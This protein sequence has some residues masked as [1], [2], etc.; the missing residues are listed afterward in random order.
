[1]Y[2]RNAKARRNEAPYEDAE[3]PVPDKRT[4]GG[5]GGW[6]MRSEREMY[7]L[8]ISTAENDDRIRA[9][10]MNG[11]RTNPNVPKD[12]FQDYDIVYVVKEN[13]PFYEDKS[14][15]DIF[16]ERLYMQCPDEVDR[17]NGMSVD[18][19]KC[20]GWLIQFQDGNRLDLHV[21]PVEEVNISEDKLCK[22]LL[23]KDGILGQ[24]PEPSDEAYRIR[25][26]SQEEFWACC[27]EFWWCLNNIAKGLWREE[28]PYVHT[29][30]YNGSHSQL[31]RLL[32]W[33]A[34]FDTDFQVSAGKASKYL[35]FY[36]PADIWNRFLKTYINGNI[37]D[38][39]RSV[40]IMCD[41]FHDAAHE[42]AGR[43]GYDYN[44]KEAEA[45]YKFFKHVHGLPKDAKEIF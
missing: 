5:E 37:E 31:V 41:L 28:I 34:G 12:I 18:F 13:A 4:G 43:C 19:D 16:G 38:I 17:W 45:S 33:K 27:N 6:E 3:T 11:S 8:I 23:D 25:R 21:I 2:G 14:W 10:Y 26:P 42:L 40:Y 36:L 24:I 22:I 35:K 44:E 29:M 15:I 32:D 30:F 1:M 9:V 20:Y 39:W 7:D